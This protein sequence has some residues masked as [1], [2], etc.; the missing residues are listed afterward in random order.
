MTYDASLALPAMMS[1]GHMYQRHGLLCGHHCE[2]TSRRFVVVAHLT[3]SRRVAI[4]LD[5]DT[6]HVGHGWALQWT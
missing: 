3:V 1:C 5:F 2:H 4:L 6:V